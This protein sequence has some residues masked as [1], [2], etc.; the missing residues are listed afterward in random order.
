[1]SE[2]SAEG[3]PRGANSSPAVGGS[4]RSER[5]GSSIYGSGDYSY[6]I[7]DN[8]AKLPEG[9]QL[10]DVAGVGVDRKDCVYLFH[11]GEHP[12]IVL[13]R[14]GNFLRSWGDGVFR[15]AHGVHMGPDD[16]IYLT[17]EGDH[18]VRKC[19][20]DG[21]VLLT[22]GVPDE[23]ATFMSGEPFRRC[24]HT[25]LSPDNH[26][27][28]SDGYGNARVHKYSPDGKRVK[29]WGEPGVGPGPVQSSAQHFLR[30]GRLGLRGRPR[31]PPHP[32]FRRQ[33]ALR[34]RVAPPA[35]AERHVYAPGEMPH[36]LCRRDRPLL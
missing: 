8:W 17:D 1:M 26:I 31:K 3:P 19:S 10:G 25:A 16:S 34:D 20:L 36:L 32:G 6:R 13:D 2:M 27:Y 9:W 11:R 35:S 14:A 21:K 28:V 4:E 18:T 12:L 5:G 29:S 15:R 22:I 7:A 30:R 23:P 24:T 33:R